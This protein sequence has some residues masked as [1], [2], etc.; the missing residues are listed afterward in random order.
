MS[1]VPVPALALLALALL[2][3]AS[4]VDAPW[5]EE[6]ALQQ[7]GTA[8]GVAYFLVAWRRWKASN[9]ALLLFALFLALH[10]VG[11]RWIYS[12]VPYDAWCEAALGF[13][14]TQACGWE[15]NHYDRFVHASYGVLATPLFAETARTWLAAARG[16]S[17][18][19]AVLLVIATSALYELGEW[20]VAFV[21]APERAD[22]YLGQQ[23]DPWDAQKDMFL[24]TAGACVTAV[25]LVARRSRS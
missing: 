22:R 4:L 20:I 10:V 6:Q 9:A 3:A 12:Y 1:R 16:R 2:L 25:V 13:R 17:I 8:G 24:A 15:R 23:G 18:A 21:A 7:F 19:V 5:P 11:A 14:P